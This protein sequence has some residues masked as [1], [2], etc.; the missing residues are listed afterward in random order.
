MGGA[1]S[2]CGA[3]ECGEGGCCKPK[4]DAAAAPQPSKKYQRHDLDIASFE[5]ED[6]DGDA[7]PANVSAAIL[8]VGDAVAAMAHDFAFALGGKANAA[9][10]TD[11]NKNSIV[12]SAGVQMPL[13]GVTPPSTAEQG[14][15]ASQEDPVA[16]ALE[17]GIEAAAVGAAA[18]GL[19]A[20][21]GGGVG[22]LAHNAAD[23]AASS[24]HSVRTYVESN[25]WSINLLCVLCGL[26]L[27][28]SGVLMMFWVFVE[29]TSLVLGLYTLFFAQSIVALEGPP[30][31]FFRCFSC[32]TLKT[33]VLK[34]AHFLAT[35]S[36]RALFYVFVGVINVMLVW[37]LNGDG[38]FFWYNAIVSGALFVSGV[39]LL[40]Q[41]CHGSCSAAP[42]ARRAAAKVQK[43]ASKGEES[44]FHGLAENA[45]HLAQQAVG[46]VKDEVTES[47]VF[48][49]KAHCSVKLVTYAVGLSLFGASVAIL[50]F[51]W[52]A[53]SHPAAYAL[54]VFNLFFSQTVMVASGENSWFRRCGNLQTRLF[55]STPG[56]ASA[57]G[58]AFYCLYIGSLN[59]AVR[60]SGA[61]WSLVFYCIG[62]A[63]CALFF[64]QIF[65][66]VGRRRARSLAFKILKR[67][68]EASAVEAVASSQDTHDSWNPQRA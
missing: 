2:A 9:A 10:A 61:L 57:L 21:A 43:D 62:G 11:G 64:V 65:V 40:V 28:G 36:G 41:S 39:L 60:P 29:P 52:T 26:G 44:S 23:A 46:F 35:K 32:F 14:E 27:S 3:V 7:S 45:G 49:D 68:A 55:D 4:S 63:F 25:H 54:A 56:L 33:V 24:F 34:V 38:L 22:A 6:T 67:E 53:K 16:E 51:F 18:A 42:A 59:I 30:E 37:A 5:A 19:A 17:Q 48:L 47:K 20:S 8:N 50:A 12:P 13:G 31:G 15:P 1:T 66:Y 58:R